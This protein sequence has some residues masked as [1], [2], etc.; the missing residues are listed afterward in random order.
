MTHDL[1]L[2]REQSEPTLF[3]STPNLHKLDNAVEAAGPASC[4]SPFDSP[5]GIIYFDYE[6]NPRTPIKLS[7]SD[8]SPRGHG[9]DGSASS[10]SSMSA[11]SH[12][13]KVGTTPVSGKNSLSSLRGFVSMVSMA[14]GVKKSKSMRRKVFNSAIVSIVFLLLYAEFNLFYNVLSARSCHLSSHLPET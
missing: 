1:S 5:S 4:E 7:P 11:A 14:S 2:G 6:K 8:G 3:K 13:S 9:T 10:L 12:D